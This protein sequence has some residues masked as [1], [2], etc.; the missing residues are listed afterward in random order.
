MP[1]KN[2]VMPPMRPKAQG[3]SD[4]NALQDESWVN[5]VGPSLP[6]KAMVQTEQNRTAKVQPARV[7][8]AAQVVKPVMPAKPRSFIER[9]HPLWPVV[10]HLSERICQELALR[11]ETTSLSE[12]ALSES[13]RKRAFELL[14]AEPAFVSMIHN[15]AEADAVLSGVVREVVG[16]GPL[17]TLLHDET[18]TE[19]TCIGPCRIYVERDGVLEEISPVFEDERHMVRGIEN[20]LRRAGQH[21]QPGCT[22]IDTRLPG[23]VQLNAVLPPNALQ[24]PVITLRKGVQQPLTLAEL[25]SSGMLSQDMADVLQA[26]VEGRLNIVVC[27]G[28]DAGRDVLLNALCAAFP[29]DERIITIEETAMLRLP[30]KQVIGLV[31]QAGGDVTMRDLLANALRMQPERLVLSNCRG[32]EAREML[33]A[34]Y[35]GYNGSLM[36]MYATS[37]ADCLTRLETVCFTCNIAVPAVPAS[38]IR[39]QLAE[40]LD[41]VVHLSRLPDGSCRI[42][43]IAEV[44]G[45]GDELNVQ[46]IFRYYDD[47]PETGND[48]GHFE[49]TGLCPTFLEK[50]SVMDIHLPCELFTPLTQVLRRKRDSRPGAYPRSR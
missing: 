28:Q 43:D 49:P 21:T 22:L 13:V 26:C 29:D 34:M 48:T 15:Q 24:G 36:S 44:S 16:Y 20:M 32:E 7:S 5:D 45:N 17:E 35:T 2:Q 18:V 37:A 11:P 4:D 30:Q 6:L 27:G 1:V 42:V 40:S 50:L 41:V 19:I 23:G 47:G 9:G 14:R 39:R 46:S 3:N 25:V 12:S 10:L 33:R 38:I 31:A 8:S